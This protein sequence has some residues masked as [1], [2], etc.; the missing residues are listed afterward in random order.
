[1]IEWLLL[2]YFSS[3][4]QT[5]LSAPTLTPRSEVVLINPAPIPTKSIEKLEP[6]LLADKDLAVFAQDLDSGMTLFEKQSDQV[7][8]IASLT[9]I[10]TYLIIRE[11]HELSEVVTV[12]LA[13]TRVEGAKVGLYQYERLTVE[14]LLEAILIPSGNDAAVAL[15]IFNAGSEDA[16]VEKMNQKAAQIGLRSAVFY[17]ASGLDIFEVV[18]SD[19][20][21]ENVID[22]KVFGNV[23]TAKE[24]ALMARVAL[25][26]DLFRAIVVKDEFYGTSTDEQFA[27]EKSS[28]NQLL[29]TFVNSKGVKTGFTGLAGQCLINLSED[30]DGREVL[31]VVLGSSDRFGE[32]KNLL[33][34]IWDS[35]TWR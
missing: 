10:M 16:F 8:P 17:N 13:A 23:M 33:T 35:F 32:T 21:C 24:A 34:W 6:K 26:D 25:Q 30:E 12:P 27:H 7:Q 1:V 9:K 4:G 5:L 29:G 31:T 22:E 11:E 3:P 15:A 18:C 20:A 28:T 2:A 14:T 19:E